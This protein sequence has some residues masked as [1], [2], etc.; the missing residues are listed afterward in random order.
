MQNFPRIS[1]QLP[2][3][4]EMFLLILMHFCPQK[5]QIISQNCTNPSKKGKM[6]SRL[7]N[8]LGMKLHGPEYLAL[9]AKYKADRIGDRYLG[10]WQTG[11][12][13]NVNLYYHKM[14][15]FCGILWGGGLENLSVGASTLFDHPP[16]QNCSKLLW[17]PLFWGRK[18]FWPPHY[19]PSTILFSHTLKPVLQF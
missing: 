10:T 12:S 3:I 9:G 7:P 6:S 14:L 13:V 5:D 16:P 15:T 18:L 1:S 8:F 4:G 2:S 17:L 19:L 11:L